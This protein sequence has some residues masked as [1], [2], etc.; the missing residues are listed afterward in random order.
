VA[1]SY[2][3]IKLNNY[4]NV[5]LYEDKINRRE[6]V[7]RKETMNM[8]RNHI[9]ELDEDYIFSK[10]FD[11]PLDE[12]LKALLANVQKD[13]LCK[14][15][16]PVLEINDGGNRYMIIPTKRLKAITTRRSNQ[17]RKNVEVQLLKIAKRG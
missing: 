9:T 10:S 12:I 3:T 14:N 13:K 7:T 17:A 16:V 4:R 1:D 2:W 5:A 15:K 11:H 8:N 6:T